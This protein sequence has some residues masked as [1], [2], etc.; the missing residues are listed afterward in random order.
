MT[1]AG[2]ATVAYSPESE[3][4]E[5]ESDPT[6]RQPGLNIQ[7]TDISIQ[8]AVEESRD[9]G[10]AIPV[11]AIEQAF[12]GAVSVSFDLAGND[13]HELVFPDSGTSFP[14][15]G[16]F[17]PSAHWYFGVDYMAGKAERVTKGTAVTDAQIQWQQGANPTVD[18]T[19]IYGAEEKNEAITPSAIEKPGE[20]DTYPFHGADLEI[21]AT[22]QTGL[23]Q[24]TLNLSQLARFRRGGDRQ[25]MDV[26]GGAVLPTLDVQAIFSEEST[27]NL[28]LA[29]GGVS[30]TAD[31]LD[32]VPAELSFE[33]GGDGAFAYDLGKIKPSDYGWADLVTPDTDLTES[34]TFNV[35]ESVEVV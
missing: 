14:S 15:G 27:D 13:W 22:I 31:T 4:L 2:A 11:D 19:M 18:L 26:V 3:F 32:A 33:G 23:Q 21:D 20:G 25:P 29:Y 7:V 12:E 17:A 30:E 16:Y 24:A 10:E 6:Y 9:P 1:G 8:Q 35:Y 28:E 5:E 34:I